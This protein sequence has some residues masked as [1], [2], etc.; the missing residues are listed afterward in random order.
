MYIYIL[1]T[2]RLTKTKNDIL[3]HGKTECVRDFLERR[4]MDGTLNPELIGE[5]LA[6]CSKNGQVGVHM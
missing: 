4:S 2:N 6:L 5:L 1:H 3:Q